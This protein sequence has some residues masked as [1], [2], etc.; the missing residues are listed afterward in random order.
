MLDISI[1]AHNLR[2]SSKCLLKVSL[3]IL[4]SYGDRAFSVAA[5][6]KRNQLPLSTST[7]Y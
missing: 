1:P 5:P 4:K 7:Q 2:S 3:S 6:K